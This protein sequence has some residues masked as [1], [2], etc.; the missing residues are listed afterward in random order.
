M[1]C[2]AMLFFVLVNTQRTALYASFHVSCTL[3]FLAYFCS[4]I[5]EQHGI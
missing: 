5:E 3:L 4:I 2:A 1:F